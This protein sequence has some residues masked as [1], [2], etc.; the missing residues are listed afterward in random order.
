MLISFV[1]KFFINLSDSLIENFSPDNVFL[2]AEKGKNTPKKIKS[3]DPL[4]DPVSVR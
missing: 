4:L 1:R 3:D 2:P